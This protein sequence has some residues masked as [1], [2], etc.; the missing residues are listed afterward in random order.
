MCF[1]PVPPPHFP[2][3]RLMHFLVCGG[4]AYPACAAA[5]ADFD[6]METHGLGL[7]TSF[8]DLSRTRRVLVAWTRLPFSA[9]LGHLWPLLAQGHLVQVT[10][11]SACFDRGCHHVLSHPSMDRHAQSHPSEP[12]PPRGR[13]ALVWGDR[14]LDSRFCYRL[15]LSSGCAESGLM[16]ELGLG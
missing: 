13:G 5:Q 1:R 15:L 7:P 2:P 16:S 11:L 4:H 9:I 14:W 6:T 8:H 3:L 10:A 12:P